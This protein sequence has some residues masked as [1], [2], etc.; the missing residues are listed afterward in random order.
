MKT[1]VFLAFM[2][3]V[4]LVAGGCAPVQ[5]QVPLSSPSQTPVQ[6]QSTIPASST[7]WPVAVTPAE[8][9]ALI[10]KTPG[11]VIVDV[12][13]AY[14][15]GHLPGAVSIILGGDLFRASQTLDPGKTYLV[16]CQGDSTGQQ[17]AKQLV[18]AGF[19]TVYWLKGSYPAWFDTGYPTVK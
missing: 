16:Y 13:S 10:D 17:G 15:Q 18:D 6:T 7:T 12:S 5:T 8:A 3:I 11:I 4:G 1:S 19:T 9:K 2:I 14:S